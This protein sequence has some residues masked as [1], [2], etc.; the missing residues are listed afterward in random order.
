MITLHTIPT[1]PRLPALTRDFKMQVACAIRR[2]GPD[3][4]R[5]RV[6]PRRRTVNLERTYQR[7]DQNRPHWE[8]LWIGY[9]DM[10]T[11]DTAPQFDRYMAAG[12]V[13]VYEGYADR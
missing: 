11:R 4:V 6:S 7:W 12:E 3:N 2:F 10:T 9:W 13:H 1:T 8:P 5:I